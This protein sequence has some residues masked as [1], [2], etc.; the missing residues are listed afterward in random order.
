MEDEESKYTQ[1][2]NDSLIVDAKLME[3]LQLAKEIE[4]LTQNDSDKDREKG[5]YRKFCQA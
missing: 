4:G 1:N 3:I 5:V 2:Q